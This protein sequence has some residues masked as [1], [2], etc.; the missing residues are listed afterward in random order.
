M[1]QSQRS[2]RQ[3]E[4]GWDRVLTLVLTAVLVF[5]FAWHLHYPAAFV[6]PLIVA[7]NL[8]VVIIWANFA[9]CIVTALLA[10]IVSI[11]ILLPLQ[12][13][14]GGSSSSK[15]PNV[16]LVGAATVS[17]IL[18]GTVLVSR[19]S[20]HLQ[21][22]WRST[23][24]ISLLFTCYLLLAYFGMKIRA[25]ISKRVVNTLVLPSLSLMDSPTLTLGGRRVETAQLLSQLRSRYFTGVSPGDEE[26]SFGLQQAAGAWRN[27]TVVGGQDVLIDC[28]YIEHPD[29]VALNAR[30]KRWI[31]YL[32]GNGEVYEFMV[33]ELQQLCMHL[34]V[35]VF[36]FNYRGVA[37]SDGVLSCT[38]DLV[39]DC[40]LCL[41]YLQQKM[42]ADPNKI[43]VFGHSIGG[44]IG[45]VARAAHSPSG[46]VLNDRSFSTIGKAAQGVLRLFLS[47]FGFDA[48]LPL[49]VVRG[50]LASVFKGRLDATESCKKITGTRIIV[51][52][53]G[54]HMIPYT[55]SGLHY[56]LKESKALQD[57][58]VS[59]ELGS[60]SGNDFHNIPLSKFPEYQGILQQCR[61]A[62]GLSPELPQIHQHFNP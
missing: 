37:H 43:L 12:H 54:D 58:V 21:F 19:A 27:V 31:L 57:G 46:P 3:L 41:D 44:A 50:L 15:F 39:E 34:G 47:D 42:G 11:V 45:T 26:A 49:C 22:N 7:L 20:S 9:A 8:P 55:V 36:A 6:A 24:L 17:A 56:D 30:D 5:G 28:A 61:R 32:L 38:S 14:T 18:V 16:Q 60:V 40:V 51:Y 29:Q 10:L 33:P 52:H 48:Y 2:I 13:L 53:T 4:T 35:N 1:K 59:I 25:W 62:L 23:L